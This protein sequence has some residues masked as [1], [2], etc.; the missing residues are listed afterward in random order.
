MTQKSDTDIT[1]MAEKAAHGAGA[2]VMVNFQALVT[3]IIAMHAADGAFVTLG[4]IPFQSGAVDPRE[5]I[6]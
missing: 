2:V 1:P 4:G 3:S 6:P 5:P